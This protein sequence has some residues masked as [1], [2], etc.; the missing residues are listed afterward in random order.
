MQFFDI[1]AL[2]AGNAG[3]QSLKASFHPAEAGHETEPKG[4]SSL[5]RCWRSGSWGPFS[6]A[7][8]GLGA[9]RLTGPNVFG[10]LR[11][12]EEDGM[13]LLRAAVELEVQPH[14]YAQILTAGR[15][16]RTHSESAIPIS[17][18]TCCSL[19]RLVT[20]SEDGRAKCSDDNDPVGLR[21]GI[22][23]NY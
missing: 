12:P 5:E 4:A 22:E 1:R 16:K 14:R 15:C 11:N 17:V 3:T 10:L 20:Q 6:V 23:D 19:A 21:R 7:A 8:I 18:G 13:R 2:L 9:M